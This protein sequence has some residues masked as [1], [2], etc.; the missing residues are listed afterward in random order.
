MRAN[1]LI[2]ICIT[3]FTSHLCR[4][5]DFDTEEEEQNFGLLSP[6]DLKSRC[7]QDDPLGM[8]SGAI[9]DGQ[10]TASSTF[11]PQNSWRADACHPSQA[12]L[13]RPNGFAWCAKFK[14]KEWIQV[15]LGVS[16]LV[17]SWEIS[18]ITDKTCDAMQNNEQT[19]CLPISICTALNLTINNTPR[20]QPS[21]L[22]Q[23]CKF[24]DVI[25]L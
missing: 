23:R 20:T 18:P 15:D 1:L 16:A 22:V 14:E 11:S 4:A 9:T 10:I 7:G 21:R 12:R 24:A 17:S 5:A 6:E 25:C 2:V 19:L 8:I 13:Y 3:L